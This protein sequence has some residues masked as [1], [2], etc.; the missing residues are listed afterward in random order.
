MRK[1]FQPA[2]RFV[3]LLPYQRVTNGRLPVNLIYRFHAMVV[4][5]C[6]TRQSASVNRDVIIN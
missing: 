5:D 6:D 4:F 1:N 2:I 3:V